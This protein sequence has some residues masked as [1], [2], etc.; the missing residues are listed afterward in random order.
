[1]QLELLDHVTVAYEKKTDHCC[2]L[3]DDWQMFIFMQSHQRKWEFLHSAGTFSKLQNH[4]PIH[5]LCMAVG[6]QDDPLVS[7]EKKSADE[8]SWNDLCP[9]W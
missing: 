4:Q 5:P 8:I 1:M 2:M 3:A 6:C 9:K 7:R